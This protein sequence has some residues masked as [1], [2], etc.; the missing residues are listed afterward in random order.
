MGKG[1]SCWQHV[2]VGVLKLAEHWSNTKVSTVDWLLL[3]QPWS[4]TN[5]GSS[6]VGQIIVQL[7]IELPSLTS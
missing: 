7:L 3:A 1:G 6:V 4:D 5:D 2:V